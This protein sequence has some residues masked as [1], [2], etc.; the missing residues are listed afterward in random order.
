[1]DESK[2]LFKRLSMVFTLSFLT[3]ILMSGIG[4]SMSKTMGVVITVFAVLSLVA[5]DLFNTNLGRSTSSSANSWG[6]DVR[7]FCGLAF[8]QRT[9]GSLTVGTQT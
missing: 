1:M 9:S 8:F 5:K 4:W 6:V 3:L 2:K 7:Y